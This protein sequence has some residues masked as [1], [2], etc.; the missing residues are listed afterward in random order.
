MTDKKAP[1]TRAPAKKVAAKKVV[2]SKPAAKKV[3]TSTTAA[4]KVAAST[5]AAT[6]EPA[7]IV[8]AAPTSN[9]GDP[10]IRSIPRSGRPQLVLAAV[11]ALLLVAIV[12]L[13]VVNQRDEGS[14][15][16]GRDATKVVEPHVEALLS[17]TPTT[18]LSEL[19]EESGWLTSDFADEYARLV[20]DTIAPAATASAVVTTAK[21]TASG[22]ESATADR[23][24]LL[25]FVNV[26][27]TSQGVT[28]PTVSG[29]RI[30]V[31]AVKTGGTWQI[32]NL[33]PL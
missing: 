25:M 30:E 4:K 33:Q 1:V 7:P 10:S 15:G 17:Y 26:S 14:P 24:V 21:V 20:T 27:T 5:T 11:A 23:V 12:T 22:V 6:P 3:V 9:S 32:K 16:A 2:A 31:T 19:Q 18:V 8:P 28:E 29:S 13:A